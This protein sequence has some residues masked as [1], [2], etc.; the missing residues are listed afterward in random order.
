MPCCREPPGSACMVGYLRIERPWLFVRAERGGGIRRPTAE[1]QWRNCARAVQWDVGCCADVPALRY[2]AHAQHDSL[3]MRM[4]SRIRSCGKEPGA[5]WA[6]SYEANNATPAQ[7]RLARRSGAWDAS[8]RQIAHARCPKEKK[9]PERK[10][11]HSSERRPFRSS[12]T[13][14]MGDVE[15]AAAPA[16]SLYEQGVHCHGQGEARA[17]ELHE[18]AA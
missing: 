11:P 6:L 3:K 9:V 8:P 16:L 12:K 7:Q 15:M 14:T 18:S 17:L 1:S 5:E 13:S 10:L 2:S 4:T